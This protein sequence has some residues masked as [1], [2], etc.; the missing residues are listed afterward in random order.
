MAITKCKECAGEISTKA[1]A[2][3]KCGA[4]QT[5]QS[6]CA[7][8]FIA[9]ILLMIILGAIGQCSQGT[10]TRDAAEKEAKDAERQILESA[11]V[12]DALKADLEANKPKILTE[13]NELL[14][15]KNYADAYKSADRFRE[16]ND[17]DLTK[18]A[19]AAQARLNE[20]IEVQ[21]KEE[22]K[23]IASALKNMKKNTDKIEGVDWYR[24]KSSPSY[25][26]RNAFYLYFGKRSGSS[27]PWLRLRIQYYSD[28]WLF[29]DSFIVVAD[30]KRFERSNVNFERDHDSEIWE[31]YDESLSASDMEMINAVISSKDATIRFNGRQYRN[32]KPITAAQKS[33]MRNVLD[34]YKA[35]GGS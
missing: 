17:S 20:E 13:I 35:A 30:G 27:T 7:Q 23:R 12:R 5:R 29:I 19:A 25:N 15:S 24:D 22:Q 26:N 31:W 3:P 6:G 14:K 34:A 33:A 8:V 4:K 32:D 1:D 21:R 10:N 2:C 11:K 9:F 28:D 18:L 16:F